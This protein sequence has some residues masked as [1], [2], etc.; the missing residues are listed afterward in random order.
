MRQAT[1]LTA[2]VMQMQEAPAIRKGLSAVSG[3]SGQAGTKAFSP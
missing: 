1:Q 3:V 2:P